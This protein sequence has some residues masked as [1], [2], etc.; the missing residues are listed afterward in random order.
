MSDTLNTIV[1]IVLVI[2]GVIW[3]WA[4]FSEPIKRFYEWIKGFAGS[5]RDRFQPANPA[6]VVKEF[7][8]S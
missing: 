4:T 1:P 3:I 7:T 6:N 2:I 5:N 8:Y